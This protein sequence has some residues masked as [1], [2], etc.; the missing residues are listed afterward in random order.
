MV[1]D[2]TDPAFTAA[3]MRFEKDFM[4]CTYYDRKKVISLYHY[5]YHLCNVCEAQQICSL[6][7]QRNQNTES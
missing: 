7:P 3:R 1:A 6:L 2:R 5:S 4:K